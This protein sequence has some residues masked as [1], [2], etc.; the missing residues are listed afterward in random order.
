IGDQPLLLFQDW[1]EVDGDGKGKIL[2]LNARY[3]MGLQIASRI[4]R[5]VGA[6]KLAQKW[7]GQYEETVKSIN[8]KFWDDARGVFVDYITPDDCLGE[9]VSEHGNYMLMD[10]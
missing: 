7:L 3:A 10:L 2:T 6:D 8:A 9:H 1:A 5:E 4:A